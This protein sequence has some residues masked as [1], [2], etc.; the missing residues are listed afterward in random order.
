VTAK[1]SA[2]SLSTEADPFFW[3]NLST[4]LSNAVSGTI[5]S[6]SAVN[7]TTGRPTSDSSI[8]AASSSPSSPVSEYSLTTQS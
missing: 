4:P 8:A 3:R 5:S 2:T 7:I 6:S 1:T